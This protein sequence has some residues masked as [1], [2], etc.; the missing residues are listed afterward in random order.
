MVEQYD[1]IVVG[2]GSAGCVVANRLSADSSRRVLLLEAGRDDLPGKEPLHIRDASFVAPY[3]PDNVWPDLRVYWEPR[4]PEKARP[5]GYLQARV[6]GGGSSINAMGEVRGLP[7]DYAL[8]ERQG[9]SGWGWADVLPYFRRIER[10]LDHRGELHG[11]SG[12][13]CIQRIAR[14]QWPEFSRAVAAA[15]DARGLPLREDI[16][17]D[18]AAGVFPIPLSGMGQSRLSAAMAYLPAEVRARGNLSVRGRT[19]VERILIEHGRV[20][21]VRAQDG[22][23]TTEYRASRV[24]I[25]AGALQTP[26]LLMRSGIGHAGQLRSLGIPVHADVPGVGANLHDHPFVT[27]AA[28]LRS[29]VRQPGTLRSPTCIVARRSSQT[30]DQMGCDQ[31]L[32]VTGKV[33]WHPF[34]RRVA[35]MNVVLYGPRSRGCVTLM[36][37]PGGRPTP[38]IEFNLL[39]DES[40]LR[41]LKDAFRFCYAIMTSSQ[42]RPLV[43]NTFALAFSWRMLRANRQSIRNWLQAAALTATLDLAGPFRGPILRRLVSPAPMLSELIGNDELLG[44]WLRQNATGFF[45]PVGTCRMGSPND[46]EAVVDAQGCVRG[47]TGLLV[48]D[49]SI[50]PTITRAGTNLTTMMIAEKIAETMLTSDVKVGPAIAKSSAHAGTHHSAS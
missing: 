31:F 35:G 9:A 25:T 49:A 47:I 38:C 3:H 15:L 28:Y 8:W 20:T 4:N 36:S 16:N 24:V 1:T 30:D 32:G 17:C 41:R 21:G 7:G 29:G 27:I 5:R 18:D 40:D 26:V 33:S 34:G 46:P 6:I 50:M 44:A 2:G 13:I 23:G 10:D 22:A 39:Q 11:D 48:A 14:E 45:H 43:L 12:P 37:G 42:V 19:T